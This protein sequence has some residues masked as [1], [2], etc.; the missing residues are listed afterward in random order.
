VVRFWNLVGIFLCTI[1]EH[2]FSLIRKDWLGFPL[3][4][5]ALSVSLFL[6]SLVSSIVYCDI[7]CSFDESIWL[8][9][10]MYC[11]LVIIMLKKD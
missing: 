6:V 10:F 11:C 3:V 9:L 1:D 4:G 7:Y 2:N 5:F 8:K